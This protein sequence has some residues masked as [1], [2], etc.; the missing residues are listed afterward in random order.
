[1]FT[2]VALSLG[3][4]LPVETHRIPGGGSVVIRRAPGVQGR[5]WSSQ[6][7]GFRGHSS[8][9]GFDTPTP[10]ITDSEISFKDPSGRGPGTS[11]YSGM[12]LSFREGDLVEITLKATNM[13]VNF[14]A[15]DCTE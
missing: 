6:P 5:L 12:K 13:R 10:T 8:V 1:M 7:P 4:L 2:V 15:M 9:F 14:T 11:S 3:M